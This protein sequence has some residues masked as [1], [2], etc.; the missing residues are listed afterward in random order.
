MLYYKNLSNFTRFLTIIVFL[1]VLIPV[2]SRAER[3]DTVDLGETGFTSPARFRK[4]AKDYIMKGI[5]GNI[6]QE[7]K[8]KTPK[9]FYKSA[10]PKHQGSPAIRHSSFRKNPGLP[11]GAKIFVFSCDDEESLK[12]ASTVNFDYGLCI[13]YESMD[14]IRDFKKSLKLTQPVGTADDE[15]L[16]A[17]GVSSYPALI[18]VHDDEFEIQEGF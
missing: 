17:F 10:I 12:M 9:L 4:T 3:E 14:E 18:T 11:I 2:S 13:E 6:P 7:T 1:D 16:K 8:P 15:T 5:S